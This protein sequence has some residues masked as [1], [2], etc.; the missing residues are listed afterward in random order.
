MVVAKAVP[1]EAFAYQTGVPTLDVAPKVRN[2]LA[3]KL[4]QVPRSMV[5]PLQSTIVIK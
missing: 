5:M 2:D 1:P 3:A 4:F